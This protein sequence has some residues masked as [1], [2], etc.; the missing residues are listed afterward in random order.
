MTI[1]GLESFILG[2]L[3]AGVGCLLVGPVAW[4]VARPLGRWPAAMAAAL[5]GLVV[6]ALLSLLIAASDLRLAGLPGDTLLSWLVLQ[7]LPLIAFLL[8]PRRT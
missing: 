7:P 8:L 4:L 6:A 2:A 5:A 3:L 1:S